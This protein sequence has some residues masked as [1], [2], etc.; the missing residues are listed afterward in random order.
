[1]EYFSLLKTYRIRYQ[2]RFVFAVIQRVFFSTLSIRVLILHSR[3]NID[4]TA[5]EYNIPNAFVERAIRAATYS[6]NTAF[7]SV[8][9]E[10]GE[11][12]QSAYIGIIKENKKKK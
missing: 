3:H 2:Q 11:I 12:N 1:L 4:Y 5:V 7:K 9:P 10:S 8:S 6:A